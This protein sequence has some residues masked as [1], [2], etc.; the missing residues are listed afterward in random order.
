VLL[1]LTDTY[2]IVGELI[3]SD[4]VIMKLKNASLVRMIA[5]PQIIAHVAGRRPDPAHLVRLPAAAVIPVRRVKLA[6]NC[7]WDSSEVAD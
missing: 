3:Y 2:T 5:D 1:V 4:D 6:V 7:T